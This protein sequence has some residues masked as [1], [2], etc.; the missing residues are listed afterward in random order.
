MKILI[1]A[2][3]DNTVFKSANLHT[4][5]AAKQF[6]GTIDV[7]IMGYA[8]DRVIDEAVKSPGVTRI[9]VAN[10]KEYE[11]Q[12][13]ENLAP[14]IA[15]IGQQYDVILAAATTYGKNLLPRTAAL[16]DMAMISD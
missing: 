15:D 13:A 6:D 11:H 7:L 2:E 10:A 14:L 4:L 8:C 5:T 9:L 1:I 3:H 12:L 16:L